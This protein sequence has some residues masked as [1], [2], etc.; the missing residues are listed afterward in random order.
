VSLSRRKA[1]ERAAY[2]E[3]G[4]AVMCF[5]NRI[6]I[7][8]VHVSPTG[9]DSEGVE[10]TIRTLP[11]HWEKMLDRVGAGEHSG[12]SRVVPSVEMLFA[13]PLAEQRFM[14]RARVRWSHGDYKKAHDLALKTHSCV[15]FG[16]HMQFLKWI[17]QR[18]AAKLSHSLTWERVEVV[19]CGLLKPPF[20][21]TG[22]QVSALCR[23]A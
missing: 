10:G 7:E 9:V 6:P 15:E 22:R 19:A 13:G 5:L 3:A 20:A 4:H 2:H 18:T 16:G 1:M 23:K 12:W 8:I 14:K 17:E 11:G 21:L